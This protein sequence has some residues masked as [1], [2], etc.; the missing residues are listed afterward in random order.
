[1]KTADFWFYSL[2]V[3]LAVSIAAG[4]PLLLRIAVIA[5]SVVVLLDVA[6]RVVQLRRV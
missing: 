1:M 4:W 3:L 2:I 6:R 5:N